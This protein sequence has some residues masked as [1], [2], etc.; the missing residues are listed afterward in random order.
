MGE[1]AFLKEIQDSFLIE[2]TELLEQAESLF[3]SLERADVDHTVTLDQLKRLAH[4]FKGSGKAV[5]FSDLSKFS[6]TIENLLVSLSSGARSLTSEVIEILLQANDALKSDLIELKA[7]PLAV[8]DH[9]DLVRSINKIV[10]RQ[11]EVPDESSR[12]NNTKVSS[13][14]AK[15]IVKKPVSK[16][17]KDGSKPQMTDVEE[18]IRV[19]I[20][21]IDDLLNSFGEQVIFLSA[22]DHYKDDLVKYQ[23]EIHRTIFNLKKLAF[24]L[25]QS[26]ITLR[27]ITLKQ[28]FSKLE[29]AVWDSA[30]M[31]GKKVLCEI[32]GADQELDKIIVD[33]L[34]DPLIHMVRNAVDHGLEMPEKR[35][36]QNKDETGRVILMARREGG[37][38]IIEIRDD[39]RGLN[40]KSIRA[41]AIEKKLISEDQNLSDKELYQLIFENG[42]STKEQ[43]SE[44]SG[45]GVGMNVVKEMIEGL[46]GTCEIESEE[47]LGTCFRIRLP[48]TL[49]L[50]NGVLVSIDNERFVVPS[51]QITEI[52][53]AKS[54]LFE[55]VQPGR[56]VFQLRERI[57]DYIQLQEVLCKP[58]RTSDQSLL[59]KRSISNISKTEKDMILISEVDGRYIGFSIQHIHGI[60]R[61]VQKPLSAEMGVCPG[62]SGVTIL[63]D[64]TPAFILSLR[65]IANQFGPRVFGAISKDMGA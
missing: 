17:I 10:D 3:L 55:E 52:V 30:K 58:S 48:L 2:A 19:P 56:R 21:K 15:P 40:P 50:F 47:G 1:D 23:D 46:K 45:R 20:R 18:S 29:R 13:L 32:Y 37:S 42:F 31:T 27:M 51:S 16:S 5:G 60:F 24:D 26:T 57:Y 49:S 63:G 59:I 33:Q 35:K 4:N 54:V 65:Q 34:A 28:T 44:L 41:K 14:F 25:Q 9:S 6:H 53:N 62:A 11:G 61:V 36:E 39:G 43:V 64:G 22:L 8:N 7:N 38:F 12:A